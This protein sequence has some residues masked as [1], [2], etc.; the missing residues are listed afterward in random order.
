VQL[1]NLGYVAADVKREDREDFENLKLLLT[2]RRQI[3][4]EPP[5][6][7]KARLGGDAFPVPPRPEVAL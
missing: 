1:T 6:G 2:T 7:A 5:A 3:N 4:H